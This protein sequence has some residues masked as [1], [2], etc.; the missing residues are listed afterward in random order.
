MQVIC[1]ELMH[2]FI[3]ALLLLDHCWLRMV[4]TERSTRTLKY[5]LVYTYP[6]RFLKMLSE[7]ERFVIDRIFLL[8]SDTIFNIVAQ[9]LWDVILSWL[10]IIVHSTQTHSKLVGILNHH[11]SRKRF[12]GHFIINRVGTV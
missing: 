10:I 2:H 4:G 7:L 11:F 5:L 1:L 8:L 12:L 9:V 3:N 6:R